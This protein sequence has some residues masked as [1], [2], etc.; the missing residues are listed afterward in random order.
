M[1][2]NPLTGLIANAGNT[3]IQRTGARVQATIQNLLGSA[4]GGLQ[5]VASLSIASQLQT[6]VSGLRQAVGNVTQGISLVQAAD[7]GVEKQ[8]QVVDRL[9]QIAVQANSGTLNSQERTSLN[10]EFQNLV[11]QLDSTA[12]NTRFNDQALLDGSFS[13]SLD[14]TLG[15]E[16][17]DSGQLLSIPSVA[18]SSLLGSG[19]I[20]VLTQEGAADALARLGSAGTSLSATRA[21]VGA[22]AETLDYASANLESAIANQ[23]AARSALSDADFAQ[24]STENSL[25]QL[26]QQA[27]IAAAV[28]GNKLPQSL[29]KLIS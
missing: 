6:T 28:Q 25:A 21:S 2:I 29:L 9:Q 11:Q 3:Q 20:N 14:T 18:A 15:G 22:F 8:Q 5:D 26:Q 16:S 13:I 10:A 1:S 7:Q 19:D 12:Q 17:G 23:D 4:S 27:A 24:A